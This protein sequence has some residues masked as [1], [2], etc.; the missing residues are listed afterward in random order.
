[1]IVADAQQG[2]SSLSREVT[3]ARP[4]AQLGHQVTVINTAV[5]GALAAYSVTLVTE[6]A[7]LQR[8]QRRQ[9]ASRA[10]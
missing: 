6:A 5:M 10:L 8:A 4:P 3:V 1:M 2:P 7:Y 9:D